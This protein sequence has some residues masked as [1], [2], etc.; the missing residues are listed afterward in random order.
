[1]T[2]TSIQQVSEQVNKAME[3]VSC[4]LSHKLAPGRS[5]HHSEQERN[6]ALQTGIDGLR[7]KIVTGPSGWMPSRAVVRTPGDQQSRPRPRYNTQPIYGVWFRSGSRSK[8]RGLEVRSREG[9]ALLSIAQIRSTFVAL[10]QEACKKKGHTIAECRELRKALHKL[11]D[12]GQI[13]RFLGHG[14]FER[15]ASPRGLSPRGR[16]LHR[17]SCHHWYHL[18]GAQLCGEQQALISEQGSAVTVPM[19]V[20]DG[21]EGPHFAAPYNDP[22]AENKKEQ[23]T[24]EDPYTSGVEILIIII[25]LMCCGLITFTVRSRNLVVKRCVLLVTQTL[26]IKRR[27]NEIHQFR[28][29]TLG[30]SLTTVLDVLDICL[31]VALLAESVPLSL[32]TFGAQ[33]GGRGSASLRPKQTKWTPQPS[34]PGQRPGEQLSMVRQRKKKRQ[35]GK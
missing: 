24:K 33:S 21:G 3:T 25:V 20:F 1:M 16:M 35:G 19:M 32:P 13:E 28:V 10:P 2:N 14:S 7:V 26:L 29:S 15:D 27:R 12:K 31:K 4:E 6:A 5:Y 22:L 17:N 30:L 8:P 11:A 34:V 23:E 18:I 9:G